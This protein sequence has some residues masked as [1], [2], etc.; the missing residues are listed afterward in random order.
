MLNFVFPN[1][2]RYGGQRLSTNSQD[3]IAALKFSY[4]SYEK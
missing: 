3:E 4:T 2:K 1:L